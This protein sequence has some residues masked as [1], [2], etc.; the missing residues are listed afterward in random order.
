MVRVAVVDDEVEMLEY[1]ENS[2]AKAF[3]ELNAEV[4]I[5]AFDNGSELVRQQS[6]MNFNI[7]FLDLEMPEMD[8]FETARRIR[9]TDSKVVLVF[10]TNREDLVFDAFQYDVTAFIRK[11]C[12]NEEWMDAVWKAY[13][14]AISRLS[15]QLFK[16]EQGEIYLRTNE[17]L[18]FSSQGHN[19]T[20]HLINGESF[21]VYYTLEQL[22]SMLVSG[23]FVRCHSGILVNCSHIYSINKDNIMLT[24]NISVVL[25]R[26]RKKVVKDTLQRN[27]RSL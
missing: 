19:V 17:I 2:I 12:L 8:G 22:E 4:E 7:I 1:L 6:E 24:G 18:Y 3:E 20:I 27:L 23:D 16:T 21:R 11:K 5:F 13:K 10:V 15:V 14:K 9:D 26:H 25:S